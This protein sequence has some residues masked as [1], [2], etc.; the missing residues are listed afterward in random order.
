MRP[1]IP[2]L[3]AQIA[4]IVAGAPGCSV[5]RSSC[6]GYTLPAP[7]TVALTGNAA[8]QLAQ[9]GGVYGAI[10]DTDG[11]A[12][13]VPTYG[14]VAQPGPS[15][16]CTAACGGGSYS[17]CTLPDDYL[18]RYVASMM[19]ADST[20]CADAGD[21]AEASI[22]AGSSPGEA[23]ST[24]CPPV[25]G[26]INVT[27]SGEPCTGRWTSG[28]ETP[29]T[30]DLRSAG[31]YFARCSYFEAASV[32]AFERL[33][34]E[35]AAH[36]APASLVQMAR[37]AARDEMRHARTMRTLAR[38]FGVE[39]TWPEAQ[40]LPVR[41][42]V[43]VAR[44]NAAEG[45]VRETYG[46]VLG[47][48]GA[49]RASNAEVRA[50]MRSIAHD[51]CGHAELSWRVAAW[52]A[53]RLGRRDREAVRRALRAAAHRLLVGGEDENASQGRILTG[54]PSGA[55][56]CRIARLLDASLFRAA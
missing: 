6:D 9:A 33:A 21:V 12:C 10:L 41:P 2:V 30:A 24:G 54:M 52:A 14:P 40:D 7:K 13:G 20:V 42:L 23:G 27:C 46:A 36:E 15:A 34:A 22:N 55:E 31:E 28:L 35:L 19:P 47:L 43:D 38:R 17:V 25:S 44:E 11:G 32:Y 53:S 39:P 45:C 56:S 50:A 5:S 4:A 26:T 3:L 48:V 51:E 37:R 1:S 18:Q 16:E 29:G 49:E 8:C